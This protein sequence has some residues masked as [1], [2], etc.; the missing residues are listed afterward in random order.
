MKKT[1]VL[2]LAL[3]GVAVATPTQAELDEQK[4]AMNEALQADILAKGYQTGWDYTFTYTLGKYNGTNVLMKLDD[5]IYI[6]SQVNDYMG[7]NKN[8]STTQQ[9]L[10]WDTLGTVELSKDDAGCLVS[11]VTTD[12]ICPTGT[13]SWFSYKVTEGEDGTLSKA[14]LDQSLNF[15]VLT[16]DYSYNT[17]D[18]TITLTH[19]GNP[20]VIDKVVLTDTFLDPTNF[21]FRSVGTVSAGAE[22]AQYGSFTTPEPATAT[23]SLLALAGLAARRRRH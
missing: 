5:S 4:A 13:G 1:I 23:L 6:V 8:A 3:A 20:V 17:G 12:S 11:T 9:D 2:M 16:I 19:T 18:T 7:L 21:E 14:N 15:A 22:M 10:K